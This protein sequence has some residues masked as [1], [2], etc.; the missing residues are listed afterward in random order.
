M[1]RSPWARTWRKMVTDA[2]QILADRGEEQIPAGT[3]LHT[4]HH[5]CA[6]LLIRQ[7]KAVEVV[8]K[9]PGHPAG[10]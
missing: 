3:T 8:P 2:H 10:H 6:S 7:G 5:T 4:L 9:R 1:Q